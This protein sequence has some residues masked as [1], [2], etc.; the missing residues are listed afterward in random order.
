MRSQLLALLLTLLCSFAPKAE[1]LVW[2]T[3][4]PL[5][6]HPV[7]DP[8]VPGS[9]LI[10]NLAF[11][12][13]FRFDAEGKLEPRLVESWQA[14]SPTRYRFRLRQGVKF[15]SGNPL[16]SA[17]VAW[18]FEQLKASPNFERWWSPITMIEALNERDFVVVTDYPFSM[19]FVRLSFLFPA[20]S[21]FVPSTAQRLSG[22]GPFMLSDYLQNLHARFEQNPQYW[23][24]ISGNVEQL[25]LIPIANKE[26]RV[27]SLFSDDVHL[28]DH[29]PLEYAHLFNEKQH[30][31]LHPVNGQDWT[32][33]Q[34]NPQRPYIEKVAVR[35]ALNF[36]I[37][38]Q[39]LA[40][41]MGPMA[42]TATQLSDPAFPSYNKS[43]TPR[44][45]PI[46]ANQLLEEA[47]VPDGTRL[48]LILPQSYQQKY[49]R[50]AGQLQ[51]MLLRT[52]FELQVEW[53]DDNGYVQALESCRY[54]MALVSRH[55][56]SG[57]VM[58][59]MRTMKVSDSLYPHVGRCG[60]YVSE[61]GEVLLRA[62]EA[63]WRS[64]ERDLLMRQLE[65]QLYDD[66]LLVPL[67][68]EQ[69]LWAASAE[70]SLGPVG[71]AMAYPHFD[72]LSL[73]QA[74]AA[75]KAD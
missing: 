56:L 25:S 13:L 70:V 50:L 57:D 35:Q 30:V 46:V 33:I 73:R 37:N 11:D 18:T 48:T 60:P 58:T 74:S 42:D 7:V 75:D 8:S 28:V 16:T 63:E 31:L 62:A 59:L 17:D 32:A 64:A 39:A 1:Q 14:E 67:Y 27:A 26:A 47:E 15:H 38:N 52:G 19:L 23:G 34:L 10:G 53:L 66:A 9:L 51:K 69:R 29:V 3:A 65:E 41:S 21:Q 72:K 49:Q 6:I 61:R 40:E 12:S 44:Y 68:W 71:F 5:A 54:D 36:A 4:Y 24:G 2:G 55:S 43:L 45:N 20:D 22:T